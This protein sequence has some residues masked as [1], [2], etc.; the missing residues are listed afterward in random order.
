MSAGGDVKER[1]ENNFVT[2][3]QAQDNFIKSL[4]SL[5][6]SLELNNHKKGSLPQFKKTDLNQYGAKSLP[7]LAEIYITKQSSERGRI[8]NQIV[9]NAI[10]IRNFLSQ[11]SSI[12]DKLDLRSALTA[13]H[14]IK[15]AE[16]RN[17]YEQLKKCEEIENQNKSTVRN[18][19]KMYTMKPGDNDVWYGTVNINTMKKRD[20]QLDSVDAPTCKDSKKLES[21]QL[22]S[23]QKEPDFKL[24]DF[25]I[26]YSQSIRIEKRLERYK[27]DIKTYTESL[28]SNKL[29]PEQIKATTNK[30]NAY[31][32]DYI[33]Q[34]KKLDEKNKKT[35]KSLNAI[36]LTQIPKPTESQIFAIFEPETKHRIKLLL[37][38]IKKNNIRQDGNLD[39]QG[40]IVAI[41]KGQEDV[42][43]ENIVIGSLGLDQDK[44]RLLFKNK[45]CVKKFESLVSIFKDFKCA[46]EAI[47]KLF[48]D[49]QSNKENASENST[50]TNLNKTSPKPN[51]ATEISQPET[52]KYELAQSQI[53]S[54]DP[55]DQATVNS[56]KINEEKPNSTGN[57]KHLKSELYAELFYLAS[58][59][60]GYHLDMRHDMLTEN[61][62]KLNEE[63]L[64]NL[65]DN[66]LNSNL[67][68]QEIVYRF[69]DRTKLIILDD[70]NSF[71]VHSPDKNSLLP[72]VCERIVN[73]F[74][75]ILDANKNVDL[76]DQIDI[77]K[78]AG[79]SPSLPL[80]P[81]PPIV[82]DGLEKS[83]S[84]EVTSS[85]PEA[86]DPDLLDKKNIENI[87]L[88]LK[89]RGKVGEVPK[90]VL[91]NVK[92]VKE[93]H[94]SEL[95]DSPKVT[96][97]TKK[98]N[99]SEKDVIDYILKDL[100]N[101]KIDEC[102]VAIE[103]LTAQRDKLKDKKAENSKYTELN[104][105]IE[106][107][108]KKLTKYKNEKQEIGI[109]L[110]LDG[111]SNQGIDIDW[112]QKANASY[113]FKLGALC[114]RIENGFYLQDN[115]EKY[116][117][118][119]LEVFKKRVLK[120]Q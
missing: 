5:L 111:F 58:R 22:S 46:Q 98:G 19:V 56:L 60:K 76:N 119:S 35:T 113:K 12:A 114:Q 69:L 48:D 79:S 33:K 68:A 59:I 24:K 74:R 70:D 87:P 91:E 9:D 64:K 14:N 93:G 72:E 67:D 73:L 28:L 8:G 36:D 104:T 71:I 75:G 103:T 2:K 88:N 43:I 21:S 31:Q 115:Y 57:S 54:L 25:I 11:F 86:L 94:T 38:E 6:A 4:N 77:L 99:L 32:N 51:V 17:A 20:A 50:V 47:P 66:I 41:Q 23:V 80:T 55:I 16:I 107:H 82:P 96:E 45:E 112:L 62:V 37:D 108:T 110:D 78:G 120:K 53:K 34:K 61:S 95:S 102:G 63:Q 92:K 26:N 81:A 84:F 116:V 85:A 18:I 83:P 100:L 39:S 90:R 40:L 27:Q 105:L 117:K 1:S 109:S 7:V 52:K 101:K 118:E 97:S 10:D 65:K 44:K 106:Q 30:L 49:I 15:C 13:E 89:K 42:K 29:N 3:E